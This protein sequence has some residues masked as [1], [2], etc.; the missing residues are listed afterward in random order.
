MKN[1]KVV[2]FFMT[3]KSAP[4]NTGEENPKDRKC[5]ERYNHFNNEGYFRMMGELLRNGVI[6]DLKVFYESNIQPGY[7]NW[8]ENCHCEVIP[9]LRFAEKYIDK[10]TIIFVRGGFRHWYDFLLKYKNKNWLIIYAANTGRERWTFWDIVFN[11]ID[12]EVNF[13]DNFERFQFEFIKPI[14]DNFFKPEKQ[15][16]QFDLCIG[17]SFIYDKKGQWRIIKALNTYREIFG[18]IRVAVPGAI[19]RSIKTN[20]LMEEIRTKPIE[21]LSF[22]GMLKKEDLKNLFNQTKVFISPNYHGQNDRGVMEA[23]SCGCI[24]SICYPRYHS[25]VINNLCKN[26][27]EIENKEDKQIAIELNN[28]IR[29]KE[30]EKPFTFE[31]RLENANEYR[32]KC[33]VNEIVTPRMTKLFEALNTM[34]EINI[35]SKRKLAEI[36]KDE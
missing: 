1:K 3:E 2:F 15:L 22:P 24:G 5:G 11:D 29:T 14:D 25:P 34:D 18:D 6:S 30:Y 27:Y 8:I 9:E 26:I 36:F 23:L 10:D 35:E 31:S 19:R 13:V 20:T 16:K 17:A 4:P 28:L 32:R 12:Q 33:G 21:G 7:A